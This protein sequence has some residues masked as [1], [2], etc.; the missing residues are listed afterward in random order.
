V[1]SRSQEF[2]RCGVHSA[3]GHDGSFIDSSSDN[4]GAV[5]E[6]LRQRQEFVGRELEVFPSEGARTSTSWKENAVTNTMFRSCSQ[7]Y[8][9]PEPNGS[10]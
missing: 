3:L 5:T 8:F 1:V 4:E 6:S 7:E 10:S 2:W 9:G